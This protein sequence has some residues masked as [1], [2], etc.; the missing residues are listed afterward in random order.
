M[1]HNQLRDYIRSFSLD[2]CALG[3][4]GYNRVLLQLF[5]YAGHG[6]SSFIN[7][8]KFALDDRYQVIAEAGETT[9]GGGYTLDRRSYKLTD[10]ITIVDNRGFGTMDN[11]EAVEVYTQLGNFLQLDKRVNWTKD[12]KD[13]VDTLENAEPNDTD[14]MLPIFVHSAQQKISEHK[15]EEIKHFQK[16]YKELSRNSSHTEISFMTVITNKHSARGNYLEV[17][18]KFESLEPKGVYAVENYTKEEHEQ[19]TPQERVLVRSM[20][21]GNTSCCREDTDGMFW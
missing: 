1:D 20:A 15:I 10:T 6:K 4:Q 19:I 16:Q 12:Y 7:S 5:G 9:D 18:K 17:E 14:V 11:F 3:S 2:D 8:C 13:I 21:R